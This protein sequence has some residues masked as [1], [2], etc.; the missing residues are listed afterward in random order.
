[1]DGQMEEWTDVRTGHMDERADGQNLVHKAFSCLNVWKK[2]TD[3][4]MNRRD[5][6]TNGQTDGQTQ[7]LFAGPSVQHL[8]HL[9]SHHVF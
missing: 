2:R 7:D 6:W 1:M 4:R 3:K 5:R 9:S 8:F